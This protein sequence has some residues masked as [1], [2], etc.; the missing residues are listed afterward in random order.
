M[1][2]IAV[3]DV[4]LTYSRVVLSS[5]LFVAAVAKSIEFPGFA[6][7]LSE[8]EIPQSLRRA[9]GLMVVA[10]EAVLAFALLIDDVA[11]PA[12]ALTT[13]MLVAFSLGIVRSLLQGKRPN[14]RCFGAL[15]AQRIGPSSIVRNLALLGLSAL[16]MIRGVGGTIF[17]IN[18]A[19]PY[20]GFI[21]SGVVVLHVVRSRRRAKR[22]ASELVGGNE[23]PELEHSSPTDSQVLVFIDAECPACVSLLPTLAMWQSPPREGP[24]LT[25]VAAGNTQHTAQLM[26]EHGVDRVVFDPGLDLFDTF[27]IDITP[28][29]ILLR[30]DERRA[31][32]FSR[33]VPEISE[34]ME[35]IEHKR[36][37]LG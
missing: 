4:I 27:N 24:T 13:L 33:G 34:L 21:L 15:S 7:N 30:A 12:A 20:L 3:E 37:A 17:E 35:G 32:R 11:Q 23:E 19:L 10:A 29:A 28:S 14:C 5:I 18:T 22:Q 25:V 26:G 8:F 9:V 31:L 1:E 6:S 16:L 2:M 36:L